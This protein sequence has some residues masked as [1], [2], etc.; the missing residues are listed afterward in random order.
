MK[1]IFSFIVLIV[2]SFFSLTSC[3]KSNYTWDDVLNDV[4]LL[5]KNN[6]AIYLE[7]NKE[8]HDFAKRVFKSMGLNISLTNVI[9]CD[10]GIGNVIYFMEFECEKQA[11]E[12][13]DYQLSTLPN[14]RSIKFCLKRAILIS[15]NTYEAI[16]LLGYKF[17]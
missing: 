16:N 2:I 5:Q 15:C 11:K 9:G 4:S 13:Y 8:N 1:K 3:I 7:N 17:K 6:F 12:L 14:D 10:K